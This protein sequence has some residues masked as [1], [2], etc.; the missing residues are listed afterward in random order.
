MPSAFGPALLI[1]NF[2]YDVSVVP[3]FWRM[4]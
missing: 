3:L 1:G 4:Q 2:N